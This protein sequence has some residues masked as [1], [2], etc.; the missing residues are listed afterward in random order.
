[1]QK[2]GKLENDDIKHITEITHI[3]IKDDKEFVEVEIM[4]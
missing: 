2:L 4:Q 3:G 1:M